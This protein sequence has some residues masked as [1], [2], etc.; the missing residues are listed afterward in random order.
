MASKALSLIKGPWFRRAA[1]AM[2]IW[3]GLWALAWGLV[4]AGL[5]Y[6][7]QTKA[8]E[9]IGREISVGKIDFK[10]WTLELQVHD[11]KVAADS[12]GK[13]PQLE[14]R[15]LY[16]DAELRSLWHLAPVIDALEVDGPVLRLSRT[17]AGRTDFDDLLKK[18]ATPSTTESSNGPQRFSLY[19]LVVRDGA[20]DFNDVSEG[21]VQT[22][23]G[24]SLSVPFL[25]NLPADQTVKVAPH[26]AFQ[27][28]GT[29]FNTG[30]Q[31]T[32]FLD[33]RDTEA[34]LQFKGLDLRPFL[35]YLPDGLPARVE[36]G[37][38]DAD[39]R[40]TF[41]QRAEPTLTLSGIL[42]IQG[43]RLSDPQGGD[44][45]SFDALTANLK[46]LQP[47]Q[48]KVHVGS[49][50]W[51]NPRA[52]VRR[53]REGQL[54]L[55][56]GKAPAPATSSPD[57]LAAVSPPWSLLV[58]RVAVAG[59]QVEWQDDSTAQPAR[60]SASDLR[61][62]VTRLVFPFDK[63]LQFVADAKLSSEKGGDAAAASFQGLIGAGSGNV[64]ASIRGLPLAMAQPYLAAV[65]QPKL[66]GTL[67]SDLGLAWNGSAW[68]AKL[69]KLSV[70]RAELACGPAR[71][72][73]ASAIAGLALRNNAAW[74]E[75]G[76]IEVEDALVQ[77]P[78]RAVSLRRV[79]VLQPKLRLERGADGRWM[80]ER[81]LA[82]K[83]P[84]TAEQA[85]PP[86]KPGRAQSDAPVWGVQLAEVS[87]DGGVLAFNDA[88]KSQPVSA[89]LDAFQL[90]AKGFGWPATG[91]ATASP[92]SLS[93][94]T[95]LAAGRSEPGSLAYEGSLQLAPLQ[96]Q[97][98]VQ[99]SRLPL[100]PF[101]R[102]VESPMAVDVIRA[103]ASFNGDVRY[104]AQA[105]GAAV[106]VRGNASLE[107]VRV[108]TLVAAAPAP[109]S[110]DA[111]PAAPTRGE[112][113]LNWKTLALQGLDVNWV[114]GKP[115][116]VDVK[117]TALSDFFA[118]IIVQ[119]NG[120]INL[121]D[122]SRP[123]QDEPTATA[124]AAAPQQASSAAVASSVASGKS[125]P[126]APVFRFGPVVLTGGSVRFTDS[127]VRPNYSADLSDLNG[128][129]SAFASVP[130]GEGS[131]PTMADLQL[132]GRAQ[133]SA[134]L[135]ITGRLNP[136]A[137]PL[138]LDIQG[139]MRDLELPPLSPYSIKYAG[140]GIEQ[141]K[142]SMD[143]N[144]RVLPDG[145]LTA[146]NKL[147]L[148][149]L[150]F[151]EPV[152]GAPASLPVRLAVALLADR[153]GV[154]DVELPINGSLND[155]QFRLGPVIF[156]AVGNLV[157]K[158]IT[159]PFSLL[160]GWM[161]GSSELDRVTFAPGSAALD[162]EACKALDKVGQALSDRPGL[163]MTVAGHAQL[164]A[165]R[166]GWK[167]AQLKSRVLAQKRRIA[168]RSGELVAGQQP[169][170]PSAQE[171]AELL[172]EV[173]RRTDI[174]KPRNLVGMAKELSVPETEALLLANIAVPDDAMR[175]LAQ[176]RGLAVRD[177]LAGRQVSLE[178]LF[179]GAPKTDAESPNWSPHAELTL[180]TR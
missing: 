75:V 54:A 164:D 90:R 110:P 3:L 63:P 172:Q 74:A 107:D 112:E 84:G 1:W 26:L 24:L 159:S 168:A 5:R 115:A 108:R 94:S 178:R 32:P 31:S 176:A 33:S 150:R 174:A 10:P 85:S 53:D 73:P 89:L 39:L 57:K 173:Y 130:P 129:L 41:L 135:E 62:N 131:E 111:A 149:K 134:S 87:V 48:R 76:R 119:P 86:G 13:E 4:P 22:L 169:Q 82:Q 17:A 79:A 126:L 163:S 77:M 96:A 35:A 177:Y 141:G 61:V 109:A 93:V 11:L 18:L 91:G 148:N 2:L 30:A 179:V 8:S 65:L 9:Q 113:L 170:A 78:L 132:R 102:Y 56:A 122:L 19:N 157:M 151:G 123:S 116:S 15:R 83:L 23:R 155:P 12:S 100:H 34:T 139:R 120:R 21:Q 127:F 166:E 64:A 165:D 128:R 67:D 147:V 36:Q 28:N 70:D 180:S 144:Y 66:S 55:L 37:T 42:Q 80:L 50:T 133:G 14:I 140:H 68:A 59:G 175:E 27:L 71:D 158:A 156:R 43:A 142:L 98:K 124:N 29:A 69:A 101:E 49:L 154:I 145:Q 7:L 88:A 125:D 44:L 136:L 162:D 51:R 38:L 52:T 6:A 47:L 143:V 16:I 114:P 72:C 137:K 46:E 167:R 103:L 81:W 118:R 161:G 40:L 160:T 99:I 106:G 92:L 153:N 95:R 60:I 152:D 25:S 20:V 45:L 104:A 138:A 58:D 121:Q 105:E 146:S 97:G 117:E 171:Y